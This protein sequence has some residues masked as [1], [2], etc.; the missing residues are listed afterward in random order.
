MRTS[1]TATPP[2]KVET[3]TP[4]Q[5]N[6]NTQVVID[7]GVAAQRNGNAPQTPPRPQPAATKEDR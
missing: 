1:P 5:L 4:S 2:A 6:K 7:Y 3:I